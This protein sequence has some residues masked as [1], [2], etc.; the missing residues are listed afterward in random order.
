MPIHPLRGKSGLNMYDLVW[1][2]YEVFVLGELTELSSWSNLTSNE[3]ITVG[4][5]QRSAHHEVQLPRTRKLQATRVDPRTNSKRQNQEGFVNRWK[6]V[7]AGTY[8]TESQKPD[9]QL[10]RRI[11]L[12]NKQRWSSNW[13]HE[14]SQRCHVD[15]MSTETGVS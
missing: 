5:G 9:G 10:H 3:Q 11:A 14:D 8:V 15:L 2:D 4:T 6:L 7:L 13:T 1:D 12:S